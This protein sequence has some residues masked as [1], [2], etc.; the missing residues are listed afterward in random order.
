[1]MW[2]V[3]IFFFAFANVADDILDVAGNIVA[4][5]DDFIVV[6]HVEAVAAVD[7]VT[8]GVV[9]TGVAPST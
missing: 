8:P 1:M 6:N 4:P 5:S 3:F 2:Q 9:V 7:I